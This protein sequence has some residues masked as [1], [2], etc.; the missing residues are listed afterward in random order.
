MPF[1]FSIFQDR[2]SHHFLSAT[3][4]FNCK[5]RISEMASQ[6]N[7]GFKV[8]FACLLSVLPFLSH[9]HGVNRNLLFSE[10][11][12]MDR[13]HFSLVFKIYSMFLVSWSLTLV[14]VYK[15]LFGFTAFGTHSPSWI[16]IY[17]T[18]FKWEIF[19]LT[20]SYLYFNGDSHSYRL[21]WGGFVC[22][23]TV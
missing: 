7:S 8:V 6:D 18:L 10:Y 13:C 19:T 21:P 11:F 9:W 1:L 20:I 4:H 2:I 17:K 15:D 16:W 12:P 14:W 23:H 22:M 3:I 5:V